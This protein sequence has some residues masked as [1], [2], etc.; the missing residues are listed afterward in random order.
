MLHS[1]APS[2]RP[3]LALRIS[4]KYIHG[5]LFRPILAKSFIVGLIK[6][7]YRILTLK[8]LG[9]LLPVQHWGRGGGELDPDILES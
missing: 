6:L 1:S 2:P 4:A 3:N 5:L 7:I 8:A 9:F